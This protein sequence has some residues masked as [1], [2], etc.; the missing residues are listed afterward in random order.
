MSN[1]EGRLV[2]RQT[3]LTIL[4]LVDDDFDL[5][6]RTLYEQLLP[7]SEPP[8]FIEHKVWPARRLGPWVSTLKI[9]NH[10]GVECGILGVPVELKMTGKGN[11]AYI[12]IINMTDANNRVKFELKTPLGFITYN[13]ILYEDIIGNVIL[14]LTSAADGRP[15]DID[16]SED[17]ILVIDHVCHVQQ[18]C[19][20]ASSGA[21][22]KKVE[23]KIIPDTEFFSFLWTGNMYFSRPVYRFM[24]DNSW[25]KLDHLPAYGPGAFGG[26]FSLTGHDTML[27]PAGITTLVIK[28]GFSEG[29]ATVEFD[30]NEADKTVKITIISHSSSICDIR[31][32]NEVGWEY[33]HAI[34]FAL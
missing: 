13:S 25:T 19:L 6:G 4:N 33:P 16:K 24:D 30:H 3:P 17:E 15:L 14:S 1:Q 5:D 9:P 32:L 26:R 22:A 18:T 23:S 34:C 27:Y 7:A 28:D 31:D 20:T 2:S 12:C 21:I 11:N 29:S 8:R 10:Y